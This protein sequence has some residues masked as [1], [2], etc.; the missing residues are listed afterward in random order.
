MFYSR[1]FVLATEMSCVWLP[2]HLSQVSWGLTVVWV[3][4]SGEISVQCL[5]LFTHGEQYFVSVIIVKAASFLQLLVC[6][7][8]NKLAAISHT[9]ILRKCRCISLIYWMWHGL[10]RSCQFVTFN[11][12]AA[13][14]ETLCSSAA[15]SPMLLVCDSKC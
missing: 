5:V 4:F 15:F 14:Q 2:L 11:C 12:S 13:L 6:K 3:Y 9:S 8:R 1:H 10:A 7:K